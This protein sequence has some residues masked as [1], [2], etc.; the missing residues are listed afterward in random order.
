MV[1]NSLC[2]STQD[3]GIQQRNP[4]I[5]PGKCGGHPRRRQ[6]EA[7][8]LRYSPSRII[9]KGGVCEG[10]RTVQEGV[11]SDCD[12]FIHRLT[13]NSSAPFLYSLDCAEKLEFWSWIS[14]HQNVALKFAITGKPHV[15]SRLW[16]L[17]E[18]AGVLH[19]KNVRQTPSTTPELPEECRET[20]FGNSVWNSWIISFSNPDFLLLRISKLLMVR[21]LTARRIGKMNKST[22]SQE[23]DWITRPAPVSR[24]RNLFLSILW[25]RFY[26][27][28]FVI[29]ICYFQARCSYRI[30]FLTSG[31]L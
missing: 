2:T 24:R 7:D 21:E 10:E 14:R 1:Y 8:C 20:L 16:W 22:E 5:S 18:R 25:S 9:G 15:H 12:F 17:W 30:C 13:E 3:L 19:H 23:S 4:K 28:K 31:R 27:L 6:E 11:L 29:Q 26:F